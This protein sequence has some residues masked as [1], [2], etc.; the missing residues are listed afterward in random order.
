MCRA[1]GVHFFGPPCKAIRECK[2]APANAF[3]VRQREELIA[4]QGHP[5]SSTWLPIESL[6]VVNS[7]LGRIS[8]R[9]HDSDTDPE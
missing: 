6:L 3:K 9:L 4:V 7:N 2:P 5:M 8:Y 1:F